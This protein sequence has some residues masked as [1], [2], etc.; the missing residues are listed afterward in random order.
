MVADLMNQ[1][2]GDNSA[3][4]LV[5]FRPIVE[6]GASIKEDHV[7]EPTGFGNRLVFGQSDTLK[8]AE[9]VEGAGLHVLQHVICGKIR[10]RDDQ[11][12][13]KVAKT[14]G[15]RCVSFRCQRVDI[16]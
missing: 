4:C 5:V 7:G 2:M 14:G 13:A 12:F 1:D 16:G 3:E 11:I 10:N 8:Q 15:Q 9:Q 6:D